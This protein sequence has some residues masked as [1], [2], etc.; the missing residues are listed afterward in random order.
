MAKAWCKNWS[1]SKIKSNRIL[2]H[3]LISISDKLKNIFSLLC[4]LTDWI[5]DWKVF[6]CVSSGFFFCMCGHYI[7]MW[8][9]S[10]TMRGEHKLGVCLKK[11][12][13]LFL[14]LFFVY[15]TLTHKTDDDD[16]EHRM[17]AILW[18][19]IYQQ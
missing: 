1:S 2:E 11:V 13:K 12:W 18:M 15:Y 3:F 19:E 16:G 4:V 7:I 17:S 9:L 6:L 5:M 14:I 8:V 10:F